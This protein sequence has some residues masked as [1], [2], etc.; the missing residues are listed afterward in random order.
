MGRKTCPLKV[1]Q[2]KRDY[3]TGVCGKHGTKVPGGVTLLR[4]GIYTTPFGK[5]GGVFASPNKTTIRL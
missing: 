5:E 1:R 4:I 2:E 3:N